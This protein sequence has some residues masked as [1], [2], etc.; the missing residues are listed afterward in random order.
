MKAMETLK[1]LTSRVLLRPFFQK[2]VVVIRFTC[3]F[4]AVVTLMALVT[5]Y[6]TRYAGFDTATVDSR[7]ATH[8]DHDEDKHEKTPG[9]RVAAGGTTP[10]AAAVPVKVVEN[11]PE[12]AW[13]NDDRNAYGGYDEN[14]GANNDRAND[15]GAN[16]D[17]ANDDGANDDGANN[18]GGQ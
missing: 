13:E 6:T 17:R 2:N 7:T 14:D 4:V 12:D 8:S 15:D 18:D 1:Q 11:P 9:V 10:S 16:N 5:Y 3:W